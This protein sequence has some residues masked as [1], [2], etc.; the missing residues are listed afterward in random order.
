[1]VFPT[2]FNLN[3]NL[4]IRSSWS[5]PH[6][7]PGLVFADCIEL[8]H[9]WLE[10]NIINLM[11]VLT[12]WWCTSVESSLALLEEGVCYDQHILLAKLCYFFTLLHFVLQDQ[13]CLL[14]KISL[15][16]LLLLSSPQWR[17]AHLFLVLVLEGLVGLHG[18]IQ[19][20]L[21]QHCWSGDR[22]GL[23]WYW[24]VCLGNKDHSV[25]FETAPKSLENLLLTMR[26]T[27]FLLRDS[28]PQ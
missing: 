23:P 20:Q 10:K 17:K 8:L 5:E 2:F 15:I 6:S 9:L 13:I 25:V 14:L 28:C 7:V 11:S 21:L 19:H 12:I 3:L 27:P 16:F 18:T 22:L 24:M 4:A 26:A 1:M